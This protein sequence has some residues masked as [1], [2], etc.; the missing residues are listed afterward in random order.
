MQAMVAMTPGPM[1]SRVAESE[2][3]ALQKRLATSS[4]SMGRFR[5]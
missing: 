4:D 5:A 1:A 2:L 3:A